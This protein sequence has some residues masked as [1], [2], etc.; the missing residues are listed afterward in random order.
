M[1]LPWAQSEIRPQTKI[2]FKPM[3]MSDNANTVLDLAHERQFTDVPPYAQTNAAKLPAQTSPTGEWIEIRESPGKGLGMFASRDIPTGT[4]ILAE[5]PLFFIRTTAKKHELD[6]LVA[7]LTP[8]QQA[9]FKS[10]ASF[11]RD[12]AETENEAIVHTNCFRTGE[13]RGGV[14]ATGSRLNHSCCPNIEYTWDQRT[15]RMLFVTRW[16]I[17]KGEEILNNYGSTYK[18]DMK[19]FWG[20]DCNCGYCN[21]GSKPVTRRETMNNKINACRLYLVLILPIVWS[22]VVFKFT[23]GRTWSSMTTKYEP[24]TGEDQAPQ[25][26]AHLG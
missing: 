21:E 16:K 13:N 10:L 4:L 8:Q 26:E 20:F 14:F 19:Q 2:S 23:V 6:A 11:R 18:Q 22:V 9:A 17:T 5:E 12:S 25:A 3:T 1:F 24:R 7:S 15:Q